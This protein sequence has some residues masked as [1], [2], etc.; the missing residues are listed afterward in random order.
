MGKRFE[1]AKKFLDAYIAN[2][3]MRQTPERYAILN[4][5]FGFEKPF[6]LDELN[7]K[8]KSS[9]LSLSRATLYNNLNLFLKINLVIK[10]SLAEKTVYDVPGRSIGHCQMVCTICGKVTSVQSIK[11]DKVINDI[12]L[13]RFRKESYVLYFYGICSNCA[14][15]LNRLSQ[16]KRKSEKKKEN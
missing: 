13:S 7:E 8:L 1:E 4:A 2:N 5:M 14:A 10:H 12:N 11:L 9:E 6:T 16:S 3:G 15:K